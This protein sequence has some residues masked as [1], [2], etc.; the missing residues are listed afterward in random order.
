M[1]AIKKILWDDIAAR[2]LSGATDKFYS[3]AQM[4]ADVES[5]H[6]QL[7][8]VFAP[9]H[10]GTFILRIDDGELVVVAAGGERASVSIVQSIFAY[11]VGVARDNRLPSV[12]AHTH[13][14]GM[15]RL[16]KRAGAKLDEFIYRIDMEAVSGRKI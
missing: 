7:M 13:K 8:G 14:A 12:R 4:K 1:T 6:V 16:M 15:G 10:I 9:G 11:V 5:G 3:V 2:H